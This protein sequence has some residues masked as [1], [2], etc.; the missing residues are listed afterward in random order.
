M[1]SVTIPN[2][3]GHDRVLNVLRTFQMQ[4]LCTAR[5]QPL[6]NDD[7]GMTL[8]DQNFF[9]QET[10]SLVAKVHSLILPQVESLVKEEYR[11]WGSNKDVQWFKDDE[12]LHCNTKERVGS[13]KVEVVARCYALLVRRDIMTWNAVETKATEPYSFDQFWKHANITYRHFAV[14][15]L[16]HTIHNAPC[17]LDKDM[18]LPRI[19][20]VWLLSILDYGKHQCSWYLTSILS[21]CLREFFPSNMEPN[22]NFL[23]DNSGSRRAA[24][25]K[26]VVSALA[27]SPKKSMIVDMI[28]DLDQF[29]L[30]RQKEIL[31]TAVN[32]ENALSLWQKSASR[33]VIGLLHGLMP[34]HL[35]TGDAGRQVQKL[36]RL[37]SFW[38]VES[39][40]QLRSRLQGPQSHQGQASS[41][42]KEQATAE[43]EI[44]QHLG[45]STFDIV[46]DVMPLIESLRMHCSSVDHK[47]YLEPL[48]II[49]SG[50]I[51]FGE[52]GTD[53]REYE[54]VI[55]DKLA[56]SI[57]SCPE[58][59]TLSG[60]VPT[61]DA[62]GSPLQVFVLAT[63]V[64]RY[65]W[66]ATYR[67][68]INEAHAINALR[69]ALA[70]MARSEM[71]AKSMFE[72]AFNTMI[73]MCLYV[74]MR[75]GDQELLSLRNAMLR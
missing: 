62:K 67:H 63:F 31:Q 46:H 60:F 42:A 48:W 65:L 4:I 58:I 34:L 37:C 18:N 45:E 47:E 57:I 69:L 20:H 5:R 28:H 16:T 68:S 73:P 10:D 21:G 64:R 30:E 25:L 1:I 44:R 3:F 72:A 15:L 71:R 55:Y 74:L 43:A 33:A 75:A 26:H 61:T 8:E 50:C 53:V 49:I 54:R 51:E 38:I 13:E 59:G 9:F 14:Y 32:S 11:M 24:L 22:Y 27:S 6:L 19:L 56:S 7:C 41:V 70:I 29:L 35:V 40:Y 12:A 52:A 2:P 39:C 23:N 17:V 36:L 66:R